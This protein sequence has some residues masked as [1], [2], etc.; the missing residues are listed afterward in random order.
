MILSL[1]SSKIT[2]ENAGGKALN[3]ARLTRAGFNVPPA[4]VL[5][6]IA[7]MEFV[8]ENE[9][10]QK[11]TRAL[12][13]VSDDEVQTLE[14]AS[15]I[16]RAAFAQGRFPAGV[17]DALHEVLHRF[18]K[19]PLAVRSSATAEDLP[20]LSFAGQQDTYLNVT[21]E[22]EL[23]NAVLG[24][25]SSLWTA[26]AIGYRARNAI[27]HEGTAIAVVIQQMVLSEISGVLFTANPLTGLRSQFVVDATFGLGEALVSGQVEPDHYVI[28]HRTGEIVNQTKGSKKLS[29]HSLEGGGIET[30]NE[31]RANQ[32]TLE[33][34]E[35]EALVDLGKQVHA[36]FDSPQDIEW[37]FSRD[38]LF[39]LQ[40][41]PITSLYPIPEL[42]YDPLLVWISFG[43]VQGLLGPMT[44]L[45]QDGIRHV[46]AGAAHLFNLR[47]SPQE[48]KILAS[49]GERLWIRISDFLRNPMGN[50]IF[51]YLMRFVEPSVMS[52]MRPLRGEP[53]LGA[54]E[55]R[56]K[57]STLRRLLGFFVPVLFR[58]VR[59]MRH[60]EQARAR[61]DRDMD[62]F[63]TSIKAPRSDDRFDLLEQSI[64][65][66]R[67][68]IEGVFEFV[69]PRFIPTLGPGMASLTL[70]TRF[71]GER[72]DLALEITRGL[73][74][75]VTTQMD[76]ALWDVA[77]S[78]KQS[79]SAR[80]LLESSTASVLA[81]RY[82]EGGLPI[83]ISGPIDG[84]LADYGMRG[85]GEI[86][87][88]RPR[89]REDPTPVFQTLRS[90][91][92]VQ[93]KDAPD[94]VFR[95]GEQAAQGA[96]D[97]L[98][99]VVRGQ[100]FGRIKARIVRFAARRARVFL[101]ARESPKFL[102]IQTMG[103]I[104]KSLLET[105][106]MFVDAGTIKEADDLFYLYVQ[107]L[108]AL[109][110]GK[111]RDWIDLIDQRRQSFDREQR[112]KLVPRVLASDGRAFYEG[113]GADTDTEHSI[114]GSPVSPGV[115]EGTVRLVFDPHETNLAPGEILVC[116]G[117]D[118][119]WTPLFL[120]AGGLV[121]E[122][123]GM[124]THGSV[125]A[126]EYG[127]PAVVGVHEATRRL[128]NGQRI[129]LDGSSGTI[130]LLD[131]T[132]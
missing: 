13:D 23:I 113:V 18:D 126:R 61:F 124:M 114:S 122:V 66:M 104:R 31:D 110:E 105:G 116:P 130:T 17:E 26:R 84:F 103:V 8:A 6:T 48:M 88:G 78:I 58:M 89:W 57:F 9:L 69:L 63:V 62:E 75:N 115:V 30:S 19:I 93:S 2:L 73:P 21:G 10:A 50:R 59:N 49:A 94:E 16:I 128:S 27:P 46:F 129:R 86:D 119:A 38:E 41:R 45:G 85:I 39:L 76:L 14:H 33:S 5:P 53:E 1:N 20:G 51:E 22:T 97:E 102:A 96:I 127:I 100:R 56:L 34:A 77:V 99:R 11:I 52:I 125:V 3:L 87:I 92:N 4:V 67:E 120:A 32:F 29:T 12:T 15:D 54:G 80:K 40:S 28:N 60:P 95:R 123:G 36:E 44:P 25:W 109:S 64:V 72:A 131:E 81:T 55:G 82:F 79:E 68:K 101:G 107:E 70:L 65:L 132:E 106:K 98:C 112:R 71:A 118:P 47:V 90:Y 121:T 117:T 37:A 108:Q 7:Y 74:D 43:S 42:S 35:I 111:G 24:C 83:E 91:L